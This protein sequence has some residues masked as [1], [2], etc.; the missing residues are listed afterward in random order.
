MGTLVERDKMVERRKRYLFVGVA[1]VG[2]VAGAGLT[3]ILGVPLLGVA[4]YLGFDWFKFRA[5]RG[6][7]F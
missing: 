5:K 4:S 7:R 2:L 3:W 6:M 1:G